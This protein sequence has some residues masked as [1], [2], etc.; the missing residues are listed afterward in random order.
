M[1]KLSTVAF[2]TAK[3]LYRATPLKSLRAIYFNMFL[4]AVRGSKTVTTVDGVTYE[5][6]LGELID[7]GLYLQQYEL[8]VEEVIK[9]YCQ[10]GAYV[11]DIGAIIGAHALRCA[12]AVGNEGKVYAFEPTDYAYQKLVRNIAL[13]QFANITPIHAALSNAN[14][15][16]QEIACRSSWQTNGRSSNAVSIVD[17]LRLDDWCGENDVDRVDFIKMDV[18]GHEFEILD[19]ARGLLLRYHPLIVMEV[20]AWHFENP[21]ANPLLLLQQLGY[22]FWWVPSCQP[23]AELTLVQSRLPSHDPQKTMSLNLIAAVALPKPF[24]PQSH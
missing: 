16:Q 12:K 10:R 1:L 24:T 14:R 15:K 2:G 3:F 13:N 20:G 8:D 18:D 22:R 5:L 9:R 23:V 21:A 19:G 11:L 6:D 7:V 4:A 17:F